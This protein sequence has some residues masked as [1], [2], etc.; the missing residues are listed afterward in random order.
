VPHQENTASKLL[1][2]KY[3]SARFLRMLNEFTFELALHLTPDL[4]PSFANKLRQ[5]LN[6]V[7]RERTRLSHGEPGDA[8]HFDQLR[9]F[10]GMALLLAH[11][12]VAALDY[13]KI[14]GKPWTR[15]EVRVTKFLNGTIEIL[16]HGYD[17]LSKRFPTVD[18]FSD[19]AKRIWFSFYDVA[20]AEAELDA[21]EI[22]SLFDT[23]TKEQ[24]AA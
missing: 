23:P 1:D 16:D 19:L 5:V 2:K 4:D 7:V 22:K 13:K 10:R 6:A 9:V 11:R 3:R 15:D 20:A 8:K 14:A 17:E 24:T 12:H 21:S 18:I